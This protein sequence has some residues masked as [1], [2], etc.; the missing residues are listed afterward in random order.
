MFSR[1]NAARNCGQNPITAIMVKW[2]WPELARAI[3]KLSILNTIRVLCRIDEKLKYL[4]KTNWNYAPGDY[5][6]HKLTMGEIAPH[7][8]LTR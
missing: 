3:E 4:E 6:H 2:V 5:A 7:I 8:W 1:W